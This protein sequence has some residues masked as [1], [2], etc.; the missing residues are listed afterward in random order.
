MSVLAEQVQL[1][2][3]GLDRVA[4]VERFLKLSQSTVYELMERGML[5]FVKIGKSRR[6]PHRAVLEFAAS[7]LVSDRRGEGG[8][9]Q[10]P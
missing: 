4:D 3:D 6:I 7:K 2:L 9:Q 8:Q 5:P 1:M 10:Q